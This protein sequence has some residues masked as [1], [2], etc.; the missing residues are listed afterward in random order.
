M[1]ELQNCLKKPFKHRVLRLGTTAYK[2]LLQWTTK[3]G[4][5]DDNS[6]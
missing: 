2:N 4:K 1:P 6:H 3:K 5:K